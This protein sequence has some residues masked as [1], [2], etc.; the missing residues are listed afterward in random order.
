MTR[1]KPKVCCGDVVDSS[2]SVEPLQA[3]FQ[4]RDIAAA[5]PDDLGDVVVVQQ[6]VEHVLDTEELVAAAPGFGDGQVQGDFQLTTD[7][8]AA[9]LAPVDTT[10][11]VGS[12]FL[13][14]A[15]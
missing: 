11:G 8:H 15:S 9:P 1:W 3:V 6:R 5:L 4:V 7:A 2:G 10:P 14:A 12:G 13:H